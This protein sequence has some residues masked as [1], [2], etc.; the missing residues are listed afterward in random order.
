[1]NRVRNSTAILVLAFLASAS[2]SLAQSDTKATFVSKCQ[3]CHGPSG[4]ANT[5][6]GKK[7]GVAKFGSD[8]VI[9]S[10]DAALLAVLKNGKGQMP[11]F[12]SKLSEAQLKDLIA[13]V[14]TLSG[15]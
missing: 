10:S 6:M 1:M 3:P 5:P 8:D 11:Q 9:K 14:R 7:L 4:D 15:K 12:G 2:L 13:Y